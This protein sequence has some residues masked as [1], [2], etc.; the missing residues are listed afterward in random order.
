MAI[1]RKQEKKTKESLTN[2]VKES[3]KFAVQL[4]EFNPLR[5]AENSVTKSAANHEWKER[6]IHA[7]TA[8]FS[9]WRLLDMIP[10]TI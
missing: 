2:K 10:T 8:Y 3:R 1:E 5:L 6:Y 4:F 7:L 9:T